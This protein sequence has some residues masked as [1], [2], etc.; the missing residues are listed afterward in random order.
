MPSQETP[1][2]Y[3]FSSTNA[4]FRRPTFRR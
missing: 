1:G 2:N 4:N 3:P